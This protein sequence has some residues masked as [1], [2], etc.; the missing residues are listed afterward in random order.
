MSY[1]VIE[2][3][4]Y[5]YLLNLTEREYEIFKRARQTTTLAALAHSPFLAETI[6]TLKSRGLLFTQDDGKGDVLLWTREPLDLLEEGLFPAM[7]KP[8]LLIRKESAYQK[9]EF[10]EHSAFMYFKLNGIIQYNSHEYSAHS[11]PRAILPA[12]LRGS[13]GKVLILGGGDGLIAGNILT[14]SPE[15]ITIVEIDKELPELFMTNEKLRGLCRDSLNHDLTELVIDDAFNLADRLESDYDLIFADLELHGTLQ[16]GGDLA[17]RYFSLLSRCSNALS[18]NG[19]FVIVPAMDRIEKEF[20][21]TL[22]APLLCRYDNTGDTLLHSP[23]EDK[24]YGLFRHFFAHV[25]RVRVDM[26]FT[27]AHMVYLCSNGALDNRKFLRLLEMK[28]LKAR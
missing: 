24:H 27:D 14:L 1:P 18:Q 11:F 3:D 2:A 7:E 20:M 26:F 19:L 13:P 25:L 6:A 10:F 23:L 15:R 21:D 4:D 17:K 12:L 9:I 22:I 8:S 16:A 28:S 5:R